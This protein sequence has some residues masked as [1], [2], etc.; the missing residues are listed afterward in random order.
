[1]PADRR[2]FRDLAVS[3]IVRAEFERLRL[4]WPALDQRLAA[5]TLR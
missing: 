1:V 5:A 4:R 2:W 3:Q